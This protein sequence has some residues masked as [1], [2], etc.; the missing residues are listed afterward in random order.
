MERGQTQRKR[1]MRPMGSGRVGRSIAVGTGLL[2]GFGPLMAQL[3]EAGP[4]LLEGAATAD[5]EIVLG[6][7]GWQV[8]VLA[9]DGQKAIWQEGTTRIAEFKGSPDKTE[10]PRKWGRVP[11][12]EPAWSDVGDIVHVD[13]H[14][15]SGMAVISALDEGRYSLWLSAEQPD[16]EWTPPW[17]VPVLE[18]WL[19]DAAFGMFDV[20]EGRDGDLLVGVRPQGRDLESDGFTGTWSGGFDV[21]RIP[22]R[23]N[24]AEAFILES[25]NTRGDEWALTPHPTTG[26]WL[27]SDG[28]AG[29]GGVDPWWC[30]RLPSGR[31]EASAPPT[32]LEGHTLTVTCGSR[33]LSGVHWRLEDAVTGMPLTRFVSDAEGQVDLSGLVAERGTRWVA[34][35][36]ATACPNAMA[37]W[38][39]GE[40]RVVQRFAL[41]GDVWRLNLLSAL[42]LDDWTAEATDRSGLPDLAPW[43]EPGRPADWVVFHEVGSSRVPAG[44]IADLKAWAKRCREQDEVH[45][46]ILGHASPEGNP[47]YNIRLARERARRVAVQLEFAGLTPQRIRVEGHG[48]EQPMEQCPEGVDCPEGL[49]E[50]SRRTELYLMPGHRP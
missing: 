28:L 18:D 6:T 9:V 16:G 4:W 40:G 41:M 26:G 5:D 15:E 8:V 27:S 36:P 47:D 20:Q 24:Y 33:P 17:R 3:P 50:R 30:S 49:R 22:R 34:E 48:S 11:A 23:G 14:L 10:T 44:R 43:L 7:D 35:R 46:L 21:V 2:F 29:P 42:A 25:L 39:D 13:L 12:R 45:V 38:T 1:G 37:V 31:R 32:R 19:G